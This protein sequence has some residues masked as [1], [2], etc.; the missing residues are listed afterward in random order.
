[1]FAETSSCR[2][3]SSSCLSS[4]EGRRRAVSESGTLR[5]TPAALN[6]RVEV[7]ERVQAHLE[8]CLNLLAAAFKHMHRHMGLIAL[9]QGYCRIAHHCYLVR[10]SHPHSRH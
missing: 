4:E 2:L 6:L 3:P 5:R 7:E 10:P 1:M 8:L 9:L